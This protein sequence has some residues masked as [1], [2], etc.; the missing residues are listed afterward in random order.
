M[1]KKLTS[2]KIIGALTIVSILSI[3]VVGFWFANEKTAAIYK[4]KLDK[5]MFDKNNKAPKFVLTLP[6]LKE[7]KEE[8]NTDI[9]AEVVWSEIPNSN[10]N[11]DTEPEGV[12]EIISH[13]PNLNQLP[14]NDPTQKLRHIVLSEPL[15]E[16]L[17]SMVLP[18]ISPE[19]L[20]PW[21]EYGVS[22][23]TMPT[24]K[25]VAV[26]IKGIGLDPLSLDKI[27]KSFA[28]EVSL[29]LS[30]YTIDAGTKI[31]SARQFGH[32]SY[33]DLLLSSKDFLK[34]DS[35]PMSMSITISQEEALARLR[36]SLAAGA[37]VGGVVI[38]DGIA[39][40][41]NRELLVAL[42]D[43][44]RKR[45]LLMIDATHGDGIEKIQLKGLARRKADIV[46]DTNF[47][48]NNIVRMLQKAEEIAYNKGQVVVVIDPKPVAIIETYNWIKSFSPQVS[49]E[50]A[51]NMELTKP[52]ALVPI[53]NLVTD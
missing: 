21:S 49:Y 43:E 45:G 41:D 32:E 25:K 42:L 50:E 4:T 16:Q 17:D 52:F 13:I 26:I 28:S 14:N 15:T 12:L 1:A 10:I 24:F 51:K 47:S 30:P 8:K 39:D 11:K 46:I 31:I 9:S 36:K 2:Y 48:R 35:G 37:P 19:Q 18:K 23:E 27:V 38:N 34:S 22:V 3:A 20:K 44:L 29:S 53:S 7:I 6:N 33:I 5:L 40:E